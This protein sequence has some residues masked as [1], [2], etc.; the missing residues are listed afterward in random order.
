MPI[1]FDDL[2][3][4]L[5]ETAGSAGRDEVWCDLTEHITEVPD[6]YVKLDG[7]S[8]LTLPSGDVVLVKVPPSAGSLKELSFEQ[9]LEKATTTVMVSWREGQFKIFNGVVC[10]YTCS[11]NAAR[12]AEYLNEVE[13][14]CPADVVHG[15]TPHGHAEFV[16]DAPPVG[17]TV[18]EAEEDSD[19]GKL[20]G[21][22]RRKSLVIP[23][24]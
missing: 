24:Q 12:D 3:D 17:A 9:T 14:I 7:Y 20:F 16:F 5:T 6:T 13:I 11:K 4:V 1:I 19:T 10:P 8:A 23:A 18:A 15:T 22:A 2:E 21:T